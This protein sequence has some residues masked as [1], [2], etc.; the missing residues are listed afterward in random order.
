MWRVVHVTDEKETGSFYLHVSDHTA[1]YW[2]AIAIFSWTLTV[3]GLVRTFFATDKS[4]QECF[5]SG[6]DMKYLRESTSEITAPD[7]WPP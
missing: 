1:L 4:V 7:G 2:S 6:G 5:C 3:T